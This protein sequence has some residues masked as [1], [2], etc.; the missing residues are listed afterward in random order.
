MSKAY[1]KSLRDICDVHVDRIE[2]AFSRI[3]HHFPVTG[4]TMKAL[5]PEDLGFFELFTS[6]F[7]K[8]QDL[9]GAKLFEA[10]LFEMRQDVGVSLRDKINQLKKFNINI[11]S[12]LWFKLRDIRNQAIHEYPDNYD[13]LAKYLNA[14]YEN[15]PVLLG[16]YQSICA[17]FEKS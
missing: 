9:M 5:S 7:G 3:K 1:V 11:D 4:K 6:R 12:V 13:L 2:L 8:L 10:L 17:S 15:T 16:I 14:L